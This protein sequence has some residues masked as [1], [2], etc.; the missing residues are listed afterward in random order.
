MLTHDFDP[1]IDLIHTA[2]IRC[3]FNPAPVASF[4]RNSNGQLTE[5]PITQY[6]IKSFLEIAD[7]NISGHADEINKLIYMRRKLEV[8]GDKGIAWQML[9]NVFHP[10]RVVPTIQDGTTHRAM[11]AEEIAAATATIS[12]SVPGFDYDRVYA[13]AH[14]RAEMISL[15]NSLQSNYEKI[16]LYRIINHGNIS[17]SVF[18]RF[19]DEVYH[20]EN[21]SLF[22]LNPAEYPT[23]PDYIIQLCDNH[24]AL[25]EA[26]ME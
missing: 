14:D 10:D 8:L 15:Y 22:Q 2:C 17:D 9:S 6:D 16:Q 25:L 23:I 7:L 21:D 18:K 20:I 11:T 13:R 3:R 1:V 26:G 4:V 5:K 24:I 19:V 12:E